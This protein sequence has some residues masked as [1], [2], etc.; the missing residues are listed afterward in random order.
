MSKKYK[1]MKK[2]PW[3]GYDFLKISKSLSEDEEQEKRFDLQE[4]EFNNVDEALL[5]VK[6]RVEDGKN[7]ESFKIVKEVAFKVNYNV[8]L[9]GDE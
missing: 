3:F 6:R 4:L 5:E 7:Y 2:N 9:D 8:E 1:I